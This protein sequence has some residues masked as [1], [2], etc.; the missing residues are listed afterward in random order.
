MLEKNGIKVKVID[1]N[2][3]MT[4]NHSNQLVVDNITEGEIRKFKPDIVGITVT[5]PTFFDV[6]CNIV[7]IIRKMGDE[8]VIV[9]GGPH[10]SALPEDTL[11]SCSEINI[12]CKGEGELS[13]LEIANGDKLEDIV[14][15]TYRDGDNIIN[16][17]NR[18]LHDNINDFCFPSRHLVDMKYYCKGNPHVMHG[19]Y[20]RATTIFTS[21]GCPYNCTFCAGSVTL[22][23]GIRFQS[24]EL[25]VEEIEILIK[26]YKI[27]GLY[28]ADDIFDVD[29]D[30]AVNICRK[31]IEKNIH[32]E[33]YWNAQLRANSMDKNLLKLMKEAGCIRVDVGFES[34]SQKTLDIINKKTTVAQNYRAAELLHE[35]GIQIHANIIVGLPGEDMEDLN[36]T[37]NFMKN[38]RPHWIGFGEFVPLP[39]SKLFDE[40]S[41]RSL[42]SKENVEVLE[43]LNF[44]KLDDENFYKFVKDVCNKIVNPIRLKNYILQNWKK[45]SALLY[46]LKLIVEFLAATCQSTLKSFLLIWNKHVRIHDKRL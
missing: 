27:E 10:V 37:R 33:I 7:R 19:I 3:L 45:P 42:I 20:S 16:N 28:F 5:T 30:R 12:A 1:R 14:G 8:T 38:I 18:K 17:Q 24:V 11:R 6:R 4:K 36:K 31:I 25:V 32:K 46:M 35:A 40:L 2:S 44:T 22:G 34:G 41:D 21:R 43:G 26:D 13:M 23:R 9:V 29:K 15:I 39:G